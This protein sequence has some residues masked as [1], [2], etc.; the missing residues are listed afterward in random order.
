MTHSKKAGKSSSKKKTLSYSYGELRKRQTVEENSRRNYSVVKDQTDLLR[1]YHKNA[2]RHLNDLWLAGVQFGLAQDQDRAKVGPEARPVNGVANSRDHDG[3]QN[4]NNN[5]SDVTNYSRN[6]TKSLFSVAKHSFSPF[7]R[8]KSAPSK[9]W[10]LNFRNLSPLYDLTTTCVSIIVRVIVTTLSLFKCIGK[11]LPSMDWPKCWFEFMQGMIHAW[12]SCKLVF[13]VL[14]LEIIFSTSFYFEYLICTGHGF[15]QVTE[16]LTIYIE[17]I[18]FS[19][20]WKYDL[21]NL[22]WTWQDV[23]S[24]FWSINISWWSKWNQHFHYLGST[25]TVTKD[26]LSKKLGSCFQIKQD[27]VEFLLDPNWL[28]CIKWKKIWWFSFYEYLKFSLQQTKIS[29]NIDSRSFLK[30]CFAVWLL[31]SFF[32][33]AITIYVEK[34]LWKIVF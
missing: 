16:L 25:L 1:G 24:Y 22:N 14:F 15:Q 32:V 11:T 8:S 13:C 10:P 17:A 33:K 23:D 30:S 20:Q 19:A 9:A 2:N 12:S 34:N 6:G 31:L 7:Q 3:N 18:V 29:A 4:G 21:F 27:Q 5:G 28:I 26:T